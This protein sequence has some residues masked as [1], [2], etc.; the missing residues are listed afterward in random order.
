MSNLFNYGTQGIIIGSQNPAN[1]A[2]ELTGSIP[3]NGVQSSRVSINYPRQE[4]VDW[5]E[6]G[7]PFLST[8]P[9]AALEFSY[10][11]AHGVN[12]SGLGFSFTSGVPA[13][14]N[15]N[16]EANYYILINQGNLDQIGYAGTNN[17]VMA[18]GNGLMTRYDFRA[19]VGQMTVCTVG[20]DC[21]NLL[22]QGT[23]TGQITPYINKQNGAASTGQYKLPSFKQN[24]SGYFEAAP[25]AITLSFDS[26]S[27]IGSALSGNVSCPLQTFGFTLDLSRNASKQLGY[28]YPD[29]RPIRWPLTISIQADAYLNGLQVDA[30]NRFGCPDSGLAFNVAFQSGAKT[31]D[32]FSMRFIGAKLGG[33]TFVEQVGAYTKVSMSWST[34]IY[35]INK[36]SGNAGNFFMNY[37]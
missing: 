36:V 1:A 6:G 33:Q 26:G 37:A 15:L 20:M 22:I 34:K 9:T 25:S 5:G 4:T 28:A 2:S 7:E 29:N 21:L 30:L 3:L 32:Y 31:V 23:G 8:R 13:L 11:F 19:A 10:V 18:F 35:D 12:E 14:V 17:Y 27:I 24:V 16:N